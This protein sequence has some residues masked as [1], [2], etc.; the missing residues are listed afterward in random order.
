M[1]RVWSA[2]AVP[3]THN[4]TPM[5]YHSGRL[6]EPPPA[7]GFRLWLSW[8][9]PCLAPNSYLHTTAAMHAEYYCRLML[10][11][12]LQTY[13]QFLLCFLF[14]LV[15]KNQT[16]THQAT[17]LT[18]SL[19]STYLQSSHHW[20]C[21]CRVL[22]QTHTGCKITNLFTVSCLFLSKKKTNKQNQQTNRKLSRPL[23]CLAPT[24]SLHTADVVQVEYY[25][26][27]IPDAKLQT[28]VQLGF[29][30][31]FFSFL[32]LSNEKKND[33]KLSW[34]LPCL[35]PTSSLHT[36][37]VVQA[38]YYCRLILDAKLQTYLH[39]VVVVSFLFLLNEKKKKKKW[40]AT[41]LTPSLPSTYLQSSHHWCCACGVPL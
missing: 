4:H 31:W 27:L 32:F 24:S 28:Y 12:K 14:F 10:H 13:L 25:C 17:E 16:L 20:W 40:W 37:D 36:T 6:R 1:S 11:A 9:F 33:R 15:K 23:P 5:S 38:E 2:V 22:L 18:P 19:P 29:F 39:F 41:E 26:R 35:A 34:P 7:L 30:C 21:A 8:S 3:F